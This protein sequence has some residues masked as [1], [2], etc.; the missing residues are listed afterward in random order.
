MGSLHRRWRWLAAACAVGLL[1]GCSSSTASTAAVSRS[2]ARAIP[3]SPG[4]V[5]GAPR[6]L[7]FR[8]GRRERLL[9]V[10][11]LTG[12]VLN[13]YAAPSSEGYAA[14][15]RQ[16]IAYL[17][18]VQRS[19][20]RLRIDWL[21]LPRHRTTQSTVHRLVTLQGGRED[22]VL[23]QPALSRDGRRLALIGASGASNGAGATSRCRTTR[24]RDVVTQPITIL[25]LQVG[26]IG[27]RVTRVRTIAADTGAV[28]DDLAW[29][30]RR[31]LVR[32]TPYRHPAT[33]FVR[34]I[35]PHASALSQARAVL[36]E[37]GGRLGP[38]FRYGDCLSVITDGVIRCV[39]HQRVLRAR[40]SGT[41][42]PRRVARVSVG[43]RSGRLLAQTR[44]G[45]TFWWDGARSQ[46]IPVTVGGHW[47]EPTW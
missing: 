19:Y 4:G 31:L 8:P 18:V 47:A 17:P 40:S 2:R 45:D 34:E 24:V 7:A 28:L 14:S 25:Y 42:L 35:G 38:V 43:D 10:D 6:F 16:R 44:N 32:A 9:V 26:P 46:L 22:D 15:L 21:A 11:A 37:P 23:A 29:Y 33:S 20:C 39:S 41:G 12:R 13:S 3:A 36:R 30:G 1:G 5:A 27:P